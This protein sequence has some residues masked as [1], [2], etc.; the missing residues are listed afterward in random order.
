MNLKLS[1][2]IF[3]AGW[4]GQAAVLQS[5]FAAGRAYYAEGEFKKAVEHLQLALKSDP[6]DSELCYWIGMSYQML[7][8]IASPFNHKYNSKARIYLTKATELAPN[9]LDYRRELFDFLLDSAGSSRAARR[10]AAS[11]LGTVSESDPDSANMRRRFEETRQANAS[12]ASRL[13]RLLLAVPQASYRIAEV[14]ASALASVSA[15]T[16][17]RPNSSIPLA[18]AAS[19]RRVGE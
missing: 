17:R 15:E 5:E 10:Q 18:P 7:A 8:D 14:P 3:L 4:G 9:R 19:V 12:V 1:V 2:L 6:N 13:G 16:S 11:M